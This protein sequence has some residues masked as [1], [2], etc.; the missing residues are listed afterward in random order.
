MIRVYD[1]VI[2]FMDGETEQVTATDHRI[3]DGVLTVTGATALAVAEHLG[4]PLVNVR[5]WRKA[6]RRTIGTE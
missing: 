2:T 1:I 4:Y 3:A 6:N 5:K